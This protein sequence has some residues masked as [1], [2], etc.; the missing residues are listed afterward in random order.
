MKTKEKR[1]FTLI[2]VLVVGLVM[3]SVLVAAYS[4]FEVLKRSQ[5]MVAGRTDAR[6]QLRAALTRMNLEF[7]HATFIHASGDQ[8][9]PIS[10]VLDGE[11]F[12]LPALGANGVNSDDEFSID[13][14]F[15]VATRQTP[16]LDPSWVGSYSLLYNVVAIKTIPRPEPDSRNPD[17]RSILLMK[18][19]NVSTSNETNPTGAYIDYA[20][21]GEPQLRKVYDTYILPG[22]FSVMPSRPLNSIA[23]VAKF[24]KDVSAGAGVSV[25]KVNNAKVGGIGLEKQSET[26][27]INIL[28]RNK[29]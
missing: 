11:T 23:I 16:P 19:T 3:S 29:S 9:S 1:A 10:V 7:S 14:G 27:T 21:L 15:I 28:I 4:V 17:A 20:N 24:T 26:H 13:A 8:T 12:V 2:E 6:S 25:D 5:L 18:W 22:D